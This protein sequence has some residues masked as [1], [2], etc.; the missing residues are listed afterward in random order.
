MKGS[1]NKTRSILIYPPSL[2]NRLRAMFTGT[3]VRSKYSSPQRLHSFDQRPQRFASA[4]S[5]LILKVLRCFTMRAQ[6]HG[7]TKLRAGQSPRKQIAYGM[8]SEPITCKCERFSANWLCMKLAALSRTGSS[9]IALSMS[10]FSFALNRLNRTV[11]K[12]RIFGIEKGRAEEE[13]PQRSPTSGE[14]ILLQ[15]E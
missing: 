7:G 10:R 8:T 1:G 6:P 15:A 5:H 11:H 14:A 4:L 13:S 12:T 2:S 3:F 9:L